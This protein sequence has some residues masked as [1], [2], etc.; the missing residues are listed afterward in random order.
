MTQQATLV[1]DQSLVGSA[2]LLGYLSFPAIED[3]R[4]H[5][6]D[7]GKLFDQYQLSRSY[8]PHEIKPHDAF[9]R[10]SKTLEG[11]IKILDAF[12]HQQSARLLVREV[13]HD[14]KRIVRHL[15]REIVDSKN[16]VLDFATVGKI[17]LDRTS[18]LVSV[19]WDTGYIAEYGYDT[20]LHQT[21]ALYTD[22][23]QYH[24]KDTVRNIVNRVITS[25]NP[26]TVQKGGRATFIP[27]NAENILFCLRDMV[28]E[29]PSSAPSSIE[30]LPLIDTVDT[31]D[32]I[33]RR[34]EESIKEE[35]HELMA[36]FQSIIAA[37][38]N[39]SRDL[40][41]RYAQKFVTI[42]G[43]IEEYEVLIHGQM[44]SV[45]H[46]LRAALQVCDDVSDEI[47]QSA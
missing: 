15:V 11:Q 29:L 9:R 44:S 13:L 19:S 26:V 33:G 3:V 16:E 34:A 39:V 36:N 31:R 46:L 32:L 18:T 17:E 6:D 1:R 42:R 37:G 25:T 7:L 22:W 30:V 35:V 27:R 12:G 43:R 8:L 28:K 47:E 5:K 45:G 38:G 14:A 23:T 41:K 20:M 10:A 40:I 24:T 21:Q 2:D 4:I